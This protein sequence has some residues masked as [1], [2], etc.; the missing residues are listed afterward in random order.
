MLGGWLLNCLVI[1][2]VTVVR[3]AV[4]RVVI[5]RVDVGEVVVGRLT[6]RLFG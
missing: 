3:V 1:G 4:G 6:V 5:R 2:K